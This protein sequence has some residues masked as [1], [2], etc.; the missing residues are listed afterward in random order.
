MSQGINMNPGRVRVVGCGSALP[1]RC[2]P[3]D[4]L[5]DTVDTTDEWIIERTGIRQRYIAA[6]DECTSDLA[7]RAARQA[8][9]KSV[10]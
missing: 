4:E 8:D 5:A 9:R 3:N 6:D 1:A 2:V 7:T 10:V